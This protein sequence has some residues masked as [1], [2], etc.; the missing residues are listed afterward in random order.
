MNALREFSPPDRMQL[1]PERLW[2]VGDVVRKLRER[3]GWKQKDLSD[4]AEIAV[5]AVVRLERSGE[6]SDQRTIYRAAKALGVS[7]ADLFSYVELGLSAHE[8]EWVTLLRGLDATRR[9]IVLNVARAE[10]D[11]QQE[12]TIAQRSGAVADPVKTGTA[13]PH[14]S[15]QS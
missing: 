4:Q 13:G 15:P 9:E 5:T 12:Q 2:T 14:G 11:H 8:A 7:V 1:V 6:N 10:R 3:K